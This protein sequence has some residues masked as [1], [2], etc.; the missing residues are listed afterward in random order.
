MYNTASIMLHLFFPVMSFVELVYLYLFTNVPGVS[1]FLSNRLCQ[2]PLENFFG[3]QRQRGRVHK[4]PSV[5][6]FIRN[7]FFF[8][9]YW[10]HTALRVIGTTCS[11]IRGNCR[12]GA[13]VDDVVLSEP[14][15][16]R[17]RK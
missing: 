8:A 5:V 7:T 12:G 11:N 9:G 14:L 13:V 17:A 10:H 16:K 2:D 1:V 3:Q 4:N 6:E 15:P